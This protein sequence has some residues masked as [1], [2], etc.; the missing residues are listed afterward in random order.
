MRTAYIPALGLLAACLSACTSTQSDRPAAPAARSIPN[1]GPI[2]AL[3]DNEPVRP[4]H[5]APSLYELAGREALREEALDRALARRLSDRGITVTVEMVR[6]EHEL[7]EDRLTEAADRSGALREEVWR[8]RH[9][10]PTRREKLFARNAALRALVAGQVTIAPAEVSLAV[11]LAYGPKKIARLI[12]LQNE[13]DAAETRRTLGDRPSS[14]DF[15]RLAER[16]SIDPSASRG[17]LLAPIHLNDPAYPIAVRNALRSL[18]T[19]AISAIIPLPEGAA[20]LYLESDQPATTPPDDAPARLERELLVQRE[21]AE[22]DRLARA[23]VAESR[24]SVLD[25]SLGWSWDE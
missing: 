22:M 25:R 23:L 2:I 13:R 10:G 4:E 3:I 14:S 11:E 15:S 9:L 21:R 7:F 24:I 8:T 5:L 18:Q 19:G 16:R 20:L 6:R 1:E 17:G 12:L